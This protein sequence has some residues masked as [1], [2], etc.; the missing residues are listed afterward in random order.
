MTELDS[1]NRRILRELERDGRLSNASL[2]EK[3]ALSPSACLR[4][5]QDL[6]KSG[7]IE[8]YSA[9]LN[10]AKLGVGMTVYVMIGLS[11]QLRKHAESFEKAMENAPEVRECHNITG[12]VEYLLRLEVADL[13]AF[14]RFH[15]DILGQRDEIARMTSHIV[16]ASSKDRRG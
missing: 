15:T 12:S 8:G 4:R 16:L 1:K 10:R 9:I 13:D 3:L 2:A 6:E 14:K 11:K 7:Y 5:V